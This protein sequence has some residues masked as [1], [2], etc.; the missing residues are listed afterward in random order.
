MEFAYDGGGLG[1]GGDVTLN[2]D[3]Q[4]VGS[5]RVPR[6]H[7]LSFSMDE[8]T[9]IG[10]DTGS[11]VTP[12]YPSTTTPSPAPSTG[13]ASRWATTATA[14]SSTPTTCSTSP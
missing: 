4:P 6:T 9:D 3:G 11:P 10:G 14:T 2:V 7:P 8:T 5:G 12:D 1:K 13:S